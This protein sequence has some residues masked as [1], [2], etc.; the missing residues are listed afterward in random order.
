VSAPSLDPYRRAAETIVFRV[1]VRGDPMLEAADVGHTFPAGTTALRELRLL[2]RRGEFLAV[3]GPSGCGKSTLLRLAAGLEVPTI[4]SLEVATTRVGYV[5]QDPT[6]LPWRSVRG[7]VELPAEL[8]RLPRAERRRR[9]AAAIRTVGL[10]G[11]EGTRPAALSGG[12]RMRASLARALVLEPDLFLFDEPF[13]ALDELTRERL[14]LEL[15][16]LFEARRFTGI[17]VT[18]SI[19]EA[20]FL[21]TRVVVMSSR[22]GRIVADVPVPFAHPREPGLRFTP[23]FG[24]LAGELSRILRAEVTPTVV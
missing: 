20:V 23:A 10:Q 16:Q 18:H 13:A 5:F 12:M 9:S 21:A 14:N 22:P 24:R 3:V 15:M 2:V 8:E 19:A 7:N 11:F 17:F 4:G 1:A 6:L